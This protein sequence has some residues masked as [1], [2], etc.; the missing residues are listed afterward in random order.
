MDQGTR[1]TW[2]DAAK[3]FAIIAVVFVHVVGKDFDTLPVHG[4]VDSAFGLLNDALTPLRMPLFFA[5]SGYF[6]AAAIGRRWRVVLVGKSLNFYYL[7]LL[8]LT[9][10]TFVFMLTPAFDTGSATSLP[11]FAA[12]AIYDLSNLWYLYA[13]AAYFPIVKLFRRWPIPAFVVALTLA[14]VAYAS[15]IPEIGL[16]KAVLRH[17]VWFLAGALFP[18]AVEWVAA[19]AGWR[20][21]LLSAALF[22]APLAA[23][24]SGAP[25]FIYPIACAGGVALGIVLAVLL[26]PSNV[27]RGLAWVGRRTLPIYVLH[28]PLLAG[29]NALIGLV[30]W[31]SV[32]LP[33]A[34]VYPFLVT[35]LV[36]A[37]AVGLHVPLGRIPWLF[38]IPASVAARVNREPASARGER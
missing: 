20:V 23:I 5:I 15:V 10:H 18:Q 6:A 13:L 36:V 22:A 37:A 7:Y 28:L 9:I 29:W 24:L 31:D 30:P 8:W 27:G 38:G 11:E 2:A 1:K 4:T 32:P 25:G 16:M 12:Q 17:L 33:L 35:G 14:A 26:A 34:V 19:R 3:G 21:L